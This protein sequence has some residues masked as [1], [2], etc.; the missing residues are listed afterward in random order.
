MF[1]LL[2]ICSTLLTTHAQDVETWHSDNIANISN[3][4]NILPPKYDFD[5]IMERIRY[6]SPANCAGIPQN[7]I[8]PNIP[9][10]IAQDLTSDT[11]VYE[12]VECTVK[13]C[14]PPEYAEYSRRCVR[15]SVPD[16][17]VRDGEFIYG[18]LTT[19]DLCVCRIARYQDLLDLMERVKALEERCRM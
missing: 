4:S 14:M 2:I 6:R 1:F 7:I 5:E 18:I 12:R 3:I 17:R 8:G 11:F 13:T 15:V 19:S 9:A 10:L 16:W